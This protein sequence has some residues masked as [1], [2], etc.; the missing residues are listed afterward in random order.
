MHLRFLC[1]KL[2]YNRDLQNSDDQ[3]VDCNIKFFNTRSFLEEEIPYPTLAAYSQKKK[4]KSPTN[5]HHLPPS[6]RKQILT[7]L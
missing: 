3:V 1:N 2:R 4:G 6:K 5:H 7:M